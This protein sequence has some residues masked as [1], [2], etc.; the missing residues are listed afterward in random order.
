MSGIYSVK[1]KLLAA[2]GHL[3]VPLI[4]ILLRNGIAFHEF[5]EVVKETYARVCAKDF[6][7]PHKRMTN[8]RVAIMTG[9]TRKEVSKIFSG[10]D[11]VKKA[12]ESNAHRVARVL[13]GW[14]NDN[15]FLG[16]YG[17]PRELYIDVDP[18]G[19]PTFAELVRRYSGDM[20]ARAMLDELLRSNTA[21]RVEE[22][23]TVKVL[24]RTY[25]PEGLAPEVIEVFARGVRRY[26]ET[27]DF[28]LTAPNPRVKRFERSVFPDDGILEDDW[29]RFREFVKE[30]LEP[31]VQ[32]L[33]TKFS[34]FDSPTQ[35]DKPALSVGVGFFIFRDDPEDAK[36]L[37]RL[38]AAEPE[39]TPPA[40][41]GPDVTD[42][43]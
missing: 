8:S 35:R 19:A 17:M 20:P 15:D 6:A 12:L 28:N 41:V 29:D 23:G 11:Q 36:T 5:A 42:L 18:A 26:V 14:H 7:M 27:V 22:R 34:W 21:A 24:K 43:D 13:Q 39:E 38:M 2:F 37:A 40:P 16:P 31:V 30:R 1:L 3:L 10:E 4:R 25:V 32:E 9:L 33:D